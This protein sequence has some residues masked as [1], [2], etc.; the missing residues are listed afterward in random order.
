MIE[1]KSKIILG[2]LAAMMYLFAI[3]QYNDPDG[4]K[5]MV[6]YLLPA[7]LFTLVFFGVYN[8][9]AA[10]MMF[11]LFACVALLYVPDL[12]AWVSSGFPSIADSM[13]ADKPLVELMREFFGLIII[14]LFLRY[15]L[16]LQP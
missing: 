1:K 14:L 3:V 8:A 12:I 2:V 5:W 13:K 16:R 6:A 4:W 9:K 11:I 7:I 15:Y 10:R